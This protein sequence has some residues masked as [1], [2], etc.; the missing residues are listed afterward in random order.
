MQA[1]RNG[2]AELG[3]KNYYLKHSSDYTNPHEKIIH[4]LLK[5]A[6]ENN[7]L[8]KKILDLCCGSGEVTKA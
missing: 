6:E 3:V 2:Y 4:K 1:V 5:I 7:Y 8:G